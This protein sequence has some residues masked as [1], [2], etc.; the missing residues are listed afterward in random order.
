MSNNKDLQEQLLSASDE[1][2]RQLARIADCMEELLKMINGVQPEE[3]AKKAKE[4]K[5]AHANLRNKKEGK[6]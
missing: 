1:N 6:K 3:L 2:N 4:H 5:K